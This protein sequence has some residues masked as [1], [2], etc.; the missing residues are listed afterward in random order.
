MKYDEQFESSLSELAYSALQNSFPDLLR[1]VVGFQLVDANDEKT[2]ALALFAVKMGSKH[3]YIPVFFVGGKLKPL[4]LIYDKQEDKFLP[5]ERDWI[6]LLSKSSDMDIGMSMEKPNVGLSAPNLERYA[7]PPR[8]GRTVTSS[9]KDM[10]S[11]LDSMLTKSASENRVP[12]PLAI[13]SADKL[14]KRAFLKL[15]EH[16][17]K[18]TQNLLEHYDWDLIKSA[19]TVDSEFTPA[20]E[21]EFY[22]LEDVLDK[23]ASVEQTRELLEEGFTV[24][25]KR[26]GA[27]ADSFFTDAIVKLE[28]VKDTGMYKIMDSS[29]DV[30]NYFAFQCTK[31]VDNNSYGTD[32]VRERLPYTRQDARKMTIVDI[33]EGIAY[34]GVEAMG[35]R[36]HDERGVMDGIINALPSVEEVEPQ[37]NYIFLL[38][39]GGSYVATSDVFTVKSVIMKDGM[40]NI[41]VEGHCDFKDKKIVVTPGKGNLGRPKEDTMAF[42]ADVKALPISS[43]SHRSPFKQQNPKLMEVKAHDQG[44]SKVELFTD[45]VDWTIRAYNNELSGLSK[46]AAV[47]GLCLALHMRGNDA[48]QLVKE[49][50]ANKRASCFIKQ[51]YDPYYQPPIYEGPQYA[52]MPIAEY[53]DPQLQPMQYWPEQYYNEQW[54][55]QPAAGPRD[56]FH[57]SVGQEN[58]N[59]QP[60]MH[61]SFDTAE[62]FSQTGDKDVMEAGTISSLSKICEIDDLIDTYLP[63]LTNAMDKIAR[64]IFIYWYKSD[65]FMDKYTDTEIKET[66]DMLRNLLKELGKTVY[67]FK[68]SK[69]ETARLINY[70]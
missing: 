42:T 25:D 14:V 55:Q 6:S 56:G 1:K 20:E 50:S 53:T 39:K 9:A 31:D 27:A 22:V 37:Q 48:M 46:K 18:Y 61:S 28:S 65:Q 35:Q 59:Q 44:V 54:F 4:E 32:F 60:Q 3:L 10:D 11:V 45:G 63:D 57:A 36:N 70:E 69:S 40:T 52:P 8:T 21:P 29:G 34:L 24:I 51:A 30:K 26:A 66:E 19:C 23:R 49:A 2:K 15:M 5:L 41:L 16:S 33:G 62:K 12:L 68:T 7:T 17:P 13:A 43:V 67:K 64:M 47:E 58:L 38:Q